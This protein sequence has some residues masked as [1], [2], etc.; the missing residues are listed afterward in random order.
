MPIKF[1]VGAADEDNSNHRGVIIVKRT[2]YIS[3]ILSTLYTASCAAPSEPAALQS[4]GA[5]TSQAKSDAKKVDPG[6]PT[7]TVDYGGALVGD[8]ATKAKVKTC[9]AS[10]MFFER[11]ANPTPACTTML[12]A[13]V[14][15]TSAKITSVMAAAPKNDYDK[16]II[17]DLAGYSLDQCL[18]CSSPSGNAYCEGSSTPKKSYPG[19]RLFWVKEINGSIDIKTLYIPQ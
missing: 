7:P 6:T 13:K 18:D 1:R 12:L 16:I 17:T 10:G 11:R 15:C 5:D 2:F 4:S 19:I 14:P 9:L 3:A 8:T